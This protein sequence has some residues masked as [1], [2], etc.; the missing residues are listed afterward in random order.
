MKEAM[1]VLFAVF[2]GLFFSA[3]AQS[4]S[5]TVTDSV[6]NPDTAAIPAIGIA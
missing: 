1:I 4:I 5:G 3:A 6:C 2:C